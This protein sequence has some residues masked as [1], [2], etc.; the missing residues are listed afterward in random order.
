MAIL[1]SQTNFRRREKL[2]FT[3]LIPALLW[4]GYYRKF[5]KPQLR[6]IRKLS[7][8]IRSVEREI[9]KVRQEQP[10][11]LPQERKLTQLKNKRIAI[12]DKVKSL[13]EKLLGKEEVPFL[14]RLLTEQITPSMDLT[15]MRAQPP[16]KQDF[17]EKFSI[18][19]SLLSNFS[20]ALT[21]I[22]SI[23]KLSPIMK[24]HD[25]SMLSDKNGSLVETRLAINAF[26]CENSGKAKRLPVSSDK[27]FTI[28]ELRDP[29]IL[30]V[31]EK[32]QPEFPKVAAQPLIKLQGIIWGEE[33]IRTV[34]IN[35]KVLRLGDEIE[36]NKIINIEKDRVILRKGDSEYPLILKGSKEG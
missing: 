7:S 8:S 35:R 21:Y 22:D 14:V 16:E 28:P 25:I 1:G 3:F 26:L 12:E 10:Q 31:T 20:E 27:S 19:L 13:Q 30:P 32:E 17:Y 36:G 9:A 23:E 33:K 29:F 6:E 4:S 24:I 15:Y 11:I 2:L 34:I 18:Q 5:Y